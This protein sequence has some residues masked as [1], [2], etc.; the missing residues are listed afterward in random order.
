MPKQFFDKFKHVK[1][2]FLP[3]NKKYSYKRNDDNEHNEPSIQIPSN[4]RLLG[5]NFSE[6]Q[7][8]STTLGICQP[9]KSFVWCLNGVLERQLSQSSFEIYSHAPTE[10]ANRMAA[11]DYNLDQGEQKLDSQIRESQ[12]IPTRPSSTAEE[13]PNYEPKD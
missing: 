4:F 9:V 13:Q 6:N 1:N 5:L 11:P 2:Q 3:Q 7:T 8:P 12:T 10:D